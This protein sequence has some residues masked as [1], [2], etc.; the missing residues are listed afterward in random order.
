MFWH[1]NP[2]TTTCPHPCHLFTSNSQ[3][4]WLLSLFLDCPQRLG[5]RCPS[6]ELVRDVE[7]AI[8]AGDIAWHAFPHNAQIELF[9]AELLRWAARSVRVLD[10]RFGRTATRTMSQR[11]VP[12]L[13]RAA[14]PILHGAG[15]RALS[16]GVNGGSAPPAVP[17]P[18]PFWWEDAASGARLLAFW[19]AGGY[20]G[21]PV[22]A[23]SECVTVDGYGRALCVAWR[24]DNAGPPS[25]SEVRA[26]F[27][28]LRR[29]WPGA[30]IRASTF[31]DFVAPL[32]EGLASGAIT[33]Q[34]PTV[35]AEIGDT[36]IHGVAS[37]PA[38]LAEFRAL[39]R[40]RRAAPQLAED[41]DFDAFSR[42]L[43]KVPEHTW[44]ADAKRAL[45]DWAAWNNSAFHAAL[46]ARAPN[47]MSI[48]HSWVRQRA[49]NVW[50][51]QELGNAPLGI[52]AWLEL[53]RLQEQRAVPRPERLPGARRLAPAEALVFDSPHWR[54]ELD[55]VS[56][57]IASVTGRGGG[58][59]GEKE[60][61]S[62]SHN[63][64]SSRRDSLLSFVYSTYAEDDFSVFWHR[65][66]YL[67]EPQPWW[68][69]MDFGKPNATGRLC[70]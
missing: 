38:K 30:D 2:Q 51:I 62:L 64:S 69:V 7:D 65:Y 6:A 34:L 56:G 32:L 20:S 44:G 35:T 59:F 47:F 9:D 24:G 5:I 21:D 39:M 68:Y 45:G 19:H 17:R 55:P 4:A 11:D 31:D 37:D 54:I 29:E 66:A 22:D 3:Q 13:T 15:V 46:A 12:G 1:A 50:A 70:F 40:L 67:P 58:E 41:P 42:L 26:V 60:E 28:L 63:K 61:V 8:R 10:R 23:P 57:G 52:A 49:Y 25:A 43:I 36:W 53:S 33:T 16:V 14:I 27:A 18:G 48:V